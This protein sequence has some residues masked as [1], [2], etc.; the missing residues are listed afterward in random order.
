MHEAIL[1]EAALPAPAK[2]FGLQM[3][4]YSLGHELWLIR[5]NSPF[6]F[7]GEAS[8]DKI[9]EAALICSET[10]DGA[11]AMN[12][13]WLLPAK[14]ALWRFRIRNEIAAIA[15]EDFRRYRERGSLCVPINPPA[16]GQVTTRRP[17]S[18]FLIRLQM[19]LVEQCRLTDS[20]AWD[21]PLG[22]AMIKR[23]AWLE[24]KESLEVENDLDIDTKNF[25]ESNDARLKA[26]IDAGMSDEE[27]WAQLFKEGLS[28]RA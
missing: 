10:W 13:D 7:G 24:E 25:Q 20:E 17:G 12:H 27:A 23:A 9:A 2:I 5:Q 19:F 4:P 22:L 1:A 6:V 15:A 21:H 3:Q 14:L 26:F 11:R 28:C 16:P 8:R 18:P